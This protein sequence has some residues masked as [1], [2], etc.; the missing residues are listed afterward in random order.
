MAVGDLEVDIRER[1]ETHVSKEAIG[2]MAQGY[3][4]VL[5]LQLIRTGKGAGESSVMEVELLGVVCDGFGLYLR[6]IDLEEDVKG[7][8]VREEVVDSARTVYVVQSS[9][10]YFVH[11]E[12][13]ATADKSYLSVS[14]GDTI[15]IPL[16]G[17]V[18]TDAPRVLGKV[19]TRNK[20]QGTNG[21]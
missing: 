5:H 3:G 17:L 13:M 2:H 19:S 6:A 18:S 12:G 1:N 11:L 7:V 14:R 9:D 16:Q 8:D 20:E 15:V 21:Y 4:G 10:D